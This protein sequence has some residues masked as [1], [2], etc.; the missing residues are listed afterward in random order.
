MILSFKDNKKSF[1]YDV[2]KKNL[3]LKST[4]NFEKDNYILE[5]FDKFY[6]NL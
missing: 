2:I 3:F 1:E 5:N 6:T 4:I